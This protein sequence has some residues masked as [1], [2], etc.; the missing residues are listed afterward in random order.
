MQNTLSTTAAALESR[1]RRAALRKGLVAT[2][3]RW[4]RNS[5]D[6]QGGFSIVD[7]YRNL[8]VHGRNFDLSAEDVI[9]LCS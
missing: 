4:R 2:K 5:I 7:P 3:T 8:V 1:A 9:E 6:N